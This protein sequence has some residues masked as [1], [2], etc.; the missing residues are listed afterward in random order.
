MNKTLKQVGIAG[1]FNLILIPLVGFSY[2]LINIDELSRSPMPFYIFYFL[3][4]T[5]LFII[6]IWCF[7]VIKEKH[8][9]NL[10]KIA[11]Y[12][13]IPL[14]S[15][16]IAGYFLDINEPSYRT[17]Q[18]LHVFLLLT[19][20]ILFII[21]IWGFKIIGEKCQNNVLKIS[22]YI[23]IVA[24]IADYGYSIADYGYF[25]F[26][27][28]VDTYAQILLR[29]IMAFAI[30]LFSIDLLGL[31]SQFGLIATMAGIFG[32]ILGTG[33]LSIRFLSLTLFIPTCILLIKILF[34]ATKKSESGLIA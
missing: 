15:I 29:A 25:H 5:I 31:K 3:A 12:I 20:L 28:P 11:P 8:Q 23:L 18:Y 4:V 19:S 16:T 32:I 21:F 13:L 9:N 14:T 7:K 17:F 33:F 10:L 30:I 6:F 1:I 22:P 2:L 26:Y 27:F 34:R 24:A